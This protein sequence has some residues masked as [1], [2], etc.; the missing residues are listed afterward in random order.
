[1]GKQKKITFSYF[2]NRRLKP[3]VKK[4]KEYYPL[5]MRITFNSK[6]AEIKAI[7]RTDE[8]E[9]FWNDSQLSNFLTRRE[10]GTPYTH[11]TDR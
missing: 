6:Q 5:Y 7:V 9:V 10:K 11:I 1:M 3:T 8:A 4:G 2:L